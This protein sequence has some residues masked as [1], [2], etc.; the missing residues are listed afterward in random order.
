MICW[1]QEIMSKHTTFR[2]GGPAA[3]YLVPETEE[4]V[5][6]A[7]RCA[8]E[9]GLPWYVI[10]RGS[11]LL[12]SD[13]GFDGVIIEIGK[14]ME[15]IQVAADGTVEAQAG[16]SLAG[17]AAFLQKESLTGFEF[18]SGIPGTLG[19][20]IT[21]NAGAYG[22]ERRD[23]IA[24]AKVLTENGD[25]LVL[26]KEEL[27]LGYRSSIIQ[28]KPYTVLSARFIFEKGDPD[29]IRERMR[30]LNQRRREKQPLEYPSAGSTF[31]R[32]EGYFAGK[33]IEDAGLRGYRV[34]DAQVS[35]KHCGFVLHRGN[36][37]AAQ[38]WQLIREVQ[39]KVREQFQVKLEPEVRMVGTFD[40]GKE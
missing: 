29:R 25:I 1:E 6:E 36:A 32:P 22:G 30:E 38:I 31:K 16:I 24:S 5:A 15:K 20:G 21:M 37:T 18:A 35:E 39:E 3:R 28:K 2:V 8:K 10:G 26:D 19:G 4:E 13:D 11:N 33:L 34:G 9:K 27:E 7:V 17:M 23:F 12:V 14:G 40:G